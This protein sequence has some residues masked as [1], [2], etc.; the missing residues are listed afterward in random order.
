MYK[1]IR[2]F[3][4][5]NSDLLYDFLIHMLALCYLTAFHWEKKA[6]IY[7]YLMINFKHFAYT[8]WNINH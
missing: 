8:F 1:Q 6:V 3:G 5:R 2:L 7:Y 4:I